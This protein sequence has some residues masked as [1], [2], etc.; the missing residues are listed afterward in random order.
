ME[1]PTR[2]AELHA[3]GGLKVVRDFSADETPEVL[4]HVG[5]DWQ[6]GELIRWFEDPDGELWADVSYRRPLDQKF[7]GTFPRQRVW[8]DRDDIAPTA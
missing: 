1:H 8:E 2:G 3:A 5:G 7:L 6:S 4:V